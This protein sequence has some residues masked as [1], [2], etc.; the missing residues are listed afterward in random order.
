MTHDS[1]IFPVTIARLGF[2]AD[3]LWCKLTKKGSEIREFQDL[4][5][6]LSCVICFTVRWDRTSE[7]SS[8][9]RDIDAL[10]RCRDEGGGIFMAELFCVTKCNVVGEFWS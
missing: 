10:G 8:V 4:L 1:M 6:H 2:C 5:T 3:F 9:G 7:I